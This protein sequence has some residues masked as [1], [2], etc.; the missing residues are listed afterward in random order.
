MAAPPARHSFP[1]LTSSSLGVFG[2]LRSAGWACVAILPITLLESTFHFEGV[3]VVA[4]LALTALAALAAWRPAAALLIVCALTPVAAQIGRQWNTSVVWPETVA[5]AFAAGWVLRRVLNGRSEAVPE[6]VWPAAGLLALIVGASIAV[7]LSVLRLQVGADELRRLML[8]GYFTGGSEVAGARAGALLLEGLLLYS[9]AAAASAGNGRF[10]TRAAVMLV[11]GGTAAALFN[12]AWVAEAGLQSGNMWRT[13]VRYAGS[14]RLNVH[15]RDLNAAGSHFGMLLLVAAAA[16]LARTSGAWLWTPAAAM[17]AFALWLTGSRAAM[18]AVAL[19]AVCAAATHGRGTI[20]RHRWSR[21][22]VAAA[23]IASV[24]LIVVYLPMRGTQQSVSAALNVRT[25]LARTSLRMLATDP[26]FGIGVGQYPQRSGS[27]SSPELLILF[28]PARNENAH[29]NFLQILAELGLAGFVAFIWILTAAAGSIR[30]KLASAP[31]DS[32]AWG[33]AAGLAAF[34]I[35]CL[36]GHPLL[37]REVAYAFWV[38]LG[39]AAGAVFATPV[40]AVPRGRAFRWMLAAAA[41]LTLA[42]TPMR[43][44]AARAE[45]NLEHV[46]LGMGSL[47]EESAD[48]VRFRYAGASSTVFVP[49]SAGSVTVPLRAVAPGARLNVQVRLDGRLANEVRV[50]SEMWRRVL[51]VIPPGDHRP[52]FRRVD[53]HVVSGAPEKAQ[54]VLMVGKVEPH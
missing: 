20:A 36:A 24:A 37:I 26:A 49:G 4:P 44:G 22:V 5:V 32:I 18:L 8:R 15:H 28:P 39:A 31:A 25:E 19:A 14:E 54:H 40:H 30:R 17:L 52:R 16:A 27:F 51:V 23:A 12:V 42:V 10:L 11:A 13:F 21:A 7:D 1:V 53:L 50:S 9:A 48:A 46:G 6:R 41:V 47:W 43:A 34:L 38:L 3:P 2:L 29:N 45:A 35:S 33:T